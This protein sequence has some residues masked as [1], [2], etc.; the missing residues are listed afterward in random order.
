MSEQPNQPNLP[1]KPR[2]SQA[3]KLK[4]DLKKRW[5]E[6]VD[7]VEKKDVPANVLQHVVVKLID[8][9]NLTIDIK[10]LIAE[11]QDPDDIEE[12][13]NDKFNELDQYIENVDFFVD[14]DKVVDTIQPQTDKVLKDL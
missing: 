8:G 3:Q 5:K 9:T 1:K 10:K 4:L 12:L 14:L 11:G 13:L 6:I 2:R 7:N